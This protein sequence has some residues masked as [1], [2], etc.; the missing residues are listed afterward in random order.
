MIERDLL[1]ITPDFPPNRGGIARYLDDLARHFSNRITVLAPLLQKNEINPVTLYAVVRQSLL[2][3]FVWPHW[4]KTTWDL[5]QRRSTYRYVITSHVLPFG[6]AAYIAQVVTKK[7]YVVMMHGMDLRLAL[8]SFRK[9]RVCEAVLRQAYL[10]VANSNALAEELFLQFGL[11][12]V[13]VVYPS[14]DPLKAIITKPES[15]ASSPFRLLTV[16]RLVDRKGHDRVL[17]AL[18]MLK[19]NGTLLAFQ[20]DIVGSGPT[21]DAL[22]QLVMELGLESHVR[23]LGDI[24]DDQLHLYYEEA[25]IFVMPVKDD[26]VDKEGFGLVFLE[27]ALFELPSITTN[28]RGVNE[29]VLHEVT[30]LLIQDNDLDMLAQSI[31]LL[32]HDVVYRRALGVSAKERAVQEFCAEKQYGKLNPYLV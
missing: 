25:D 18:A 5:I 26:P 9:K 15:S 32:S 30:G 16:S 21:K 7:P 14:V 11:S 27:A 1:L 17:T 19:L 3:H 2:F 13:I 20:Y 6:T 8:T 28:I 4:F 23:F 10:V 22:E 31:T 12:N 24:P 29:A